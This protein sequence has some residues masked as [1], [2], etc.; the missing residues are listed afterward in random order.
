MM[1]DTLNISLNGLHLGPVALINLAAL[2]QVEAS[3]FHNSLHLYQRD[4]NLYLRHRAPPQ[5]TPRDQNFEAELGVILAASAIVFA[6]PLVTVPKEMALPLLVQKPID[7]IDEAPEPELVLIAPSRDGNSDLARPVDAA[8]QKVLLNAV[9][10]QEIKFVPVDTEQNDIY[11]LV[12]TALLTGAHE[13][14]D[15]PL[16]EQVL[17]GF[18]SKLPLDLHFDADGL[19]Y[20]RDVMNG[21]ADFLFSQQSSFRAASIEIS[22]TNGELF[23]LDE[24]QEYFDASGGLIEGG[25]SSATVEIE[26]A[27]SFFSRLVV[28]LR[29]EAEKVDIGI[30]ITTASQEIIVATNI[31]IHAVDIDTEPAPIIDDRVGLPDDEILSETAARDDSV[32][33]LRSLSPEEDLSGDLFHL[34]PDVV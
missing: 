22:V 16:G 11:D 9:Q 33:T 32:S 26:K 27:E 10:Q 6:S 19:F 31:V 28:Q 12:R 29:E 24:D 25:F 1:T 4:A 7:D 34:P 8:Q 13:E 17:L 23:L 20:F 15:V 18:E 21:E 5:K 30:E 3:P 14:V 2:P